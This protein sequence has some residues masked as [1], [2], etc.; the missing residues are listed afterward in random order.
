MVSDYTHSKT[1][2]LEK[3]NE[4]FSFLTSIGLSYC[5]ITVVKLFSFQPRYI[6]SNN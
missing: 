4:L 3:T 1:I 6:K 5:Y 2:L